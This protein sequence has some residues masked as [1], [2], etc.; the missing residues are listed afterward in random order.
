[1]IG[2]DI[3]KLV[4]TFENID[5][6]KLIRDTEE[7]VSAATEAVIVQREMLDVLTLMAELLEA[8]LLVAKKDFRPQSKEPYDRYT[9]ID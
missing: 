5:F 1:M 4:K 8:N 3:L 7:A 2:T 6:E 9:V